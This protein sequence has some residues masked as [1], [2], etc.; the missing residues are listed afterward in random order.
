MDKLPSSRA[1]A[2]SL[3]RVVISACALPLIS[4]GVVS[5]HGRLEEPPAATN[6]GPND[7]YQFCFGGDCPCGNDYEGPGPM[8][9]AYVEGQ[10]IRIVLN[11]TVTH[12]AEDYFRFQLCPSVD[13][14]SEA[15]FVE[16]EFAQ[17]PNEDLSGTQSYE[18][19]LPSG[20]SCESCILRWRWDYGFLGCAHIQITP[21]TTPQFTRADCNRDGLYDISDVVHHLLG[22]FREG[23]IGCD[24]ACDSNDDGTLDVSDAISALR[25]LF[26]GQGSIPGPG[27]KGCGTDPT[28]DEL[29]CE[30]YESCP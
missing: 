7:D 2:S 3:R 16:G 12:G 27:M 23:T 20:I 24:D 5:A 30:Q 21:A 28:G 13:D 8:V 10:T 11:I 26:L 22:I 17:V 15:C 29:G 6:G 9:A 1:L 18:V 14:V 19:T 4:A 25:V